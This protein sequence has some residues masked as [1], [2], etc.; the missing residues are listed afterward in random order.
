VFGYGKRGTIE[1]IFAERRSVVYEVLV[2][3]L[4]D[5]LRSGRRQPGE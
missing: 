3:Q 5:R 2:E 4:L 1:C